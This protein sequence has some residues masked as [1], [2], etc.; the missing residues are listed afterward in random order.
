[1]WTQAWNRFISSQ[2]SRDAAGSCG[3]RGREFKEGRGDGGQW[4]KDI[5]SDSG[6]GVRIVRFKL[7]R[8]GCAGWF[9]LVRFGELVDAVGAAAQ[10]RCLQG[11]YP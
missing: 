3:S 8:K 11:P 6:V 5:K 2:S 10:F 9:F 7:V 4:W 1:M